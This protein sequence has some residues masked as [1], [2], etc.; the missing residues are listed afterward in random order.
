MEDKLNSNYKRMCLDE[1]QKLTEKSDENLVKR[2]HHIRNSLLDTIYSADKNH[3]NDDEDMEKVVVVFN[4][5]EDYADEFSQ[6]G[7][8]PDFDGF[9]REISPLIENLRHKFKM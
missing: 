5:I 9:V 4:M 6:M 3:S 1:L 8:D 7:N 2:V